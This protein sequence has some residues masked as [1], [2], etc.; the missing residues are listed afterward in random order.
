MQHEHIWRMSWTLKVTTSD[1]CYFLIQWVV[2]ITRS[3]NS[4]FLA[5]SVLRM[6]NMAEMALRAPIT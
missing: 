1:N 6:V 3:D 5:G 4:Y 2:K